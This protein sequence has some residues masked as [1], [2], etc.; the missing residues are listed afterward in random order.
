MTEQ[1]KMTLS[2]IKTRAEDLIVRLNKTEIDN[3]ERWYAI[4][5]NI[6]YTTIIFIKN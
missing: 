1:L 5:S 2:L 4:I 3:P 6:Y